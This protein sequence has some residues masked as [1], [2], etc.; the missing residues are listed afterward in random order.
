[1]RQE[2]QGLLITPLQ[3]HFDI[4]G[5]IS[6]SITEKPLQMPK[7]FHNSMSLQQTTKPNQNPQLTPN[8]PKHRQNANTPQQ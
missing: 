8:N 3:G 1:M 7:N 6:R 5:V 4:M 2:P